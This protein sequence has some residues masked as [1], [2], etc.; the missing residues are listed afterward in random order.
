MWDRIK[1]HT[2]IKL[3]EFETLDPA[4]EA[5]Q[6]NIDALGFHF[7]AHHAFEERLKRFSEI[8]KYLP[9]RVDKVL[10]ADIEFEPL[11]RFCTELPVDCIQLYPD[12]T[13]HQID[14]LRKRLPATRIIK[15]ISAQPSEN[16]FPETTS[17]LS[18]YSAVVDGFLLDSWKKGGT[19]KVAD[20]NHCARVVKESPLP[21]FLAGGLT[22]EN[23]SE[24]MRIVRPFSVD[25]ET[26]VSDRIPGGPLVKN[27]Q[28][29]RRF[30][31]AVR[32]ADKELASPSTTHPLRG[33]G[34][35]NQ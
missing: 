20:W 30:V 11:I 5:S 32:K 22:P 10:L 8:F 34:V 35:C 17:L 9:T 13:A 1:T 27:M 26:G 2:R 14:L 4:Y 6:L 7:L 28:K 21:V 19:G 29:C 33:M 18:Y 15:V 3:C 24:A 12:W 23:V 16:K 25:V 31:D